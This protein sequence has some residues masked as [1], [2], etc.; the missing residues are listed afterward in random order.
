MLRL[1]RPRGPGL[2]RSTAAPGRMLFS[3]AVPLFDRRIEDVRGH[4]AS[5][6]ARREL[7]R[8]DPPFAFWRRQIDLDDFEAL[9]RHFRDRARILSRHLGA[10]TLLRL[11]GRA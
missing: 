5:P 8:L 3:I 6:H 1:T 7:L 9:L 10:Q 4:E 2:L 11:Q